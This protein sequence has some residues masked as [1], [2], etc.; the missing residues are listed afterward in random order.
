M[1]PTASLA[2][3]GYYF[4]DA[5]DTLVKVTVPCE[6]ACAGAEL[7]KDGAVSCVFTD[8]SFKLDVTV[9]GCVHK[10][11]VGELS[12][13]IKPSESCTKV[14]MKTKKVMVEL[15]KAESGKKWKKLTAL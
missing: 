12:H 8:F 10:L 4:E 7:P 5:N 15:V 3:C 6:A 13:R 14:R 11:D 1:L 2:K 9:G